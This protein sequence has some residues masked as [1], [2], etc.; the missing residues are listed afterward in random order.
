MIRKRRI[1]LPALI[2]FLIALALPVS[3]IWQE[4]RQAQRHQV[5]IATRQHT[6]VA[7][8][9]SVNRTQSLSALALAVQSNNTTLVQAL[10]MCQGF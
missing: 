8:D 4:W 5:F 1:S 3:L 9:A 7:P 6:D 2:V 10:G